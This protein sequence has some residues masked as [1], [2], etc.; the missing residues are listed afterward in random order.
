M[1]FSKSIPTIDNIREPIL[2]LVSESPHVASFIGG[3]IARGWAHA[4]SDVDVVVVVDALPSGDD[5]EQV[6]AGRSAVRVR[7]AVVAGRRCELKYWLA[8][9]LDEAIER[10]SWSSFDR[11]EA[12]FHNEERVLL[13]R[14]GWGVVLTGSPW[15]QSRI[16]LLS[17]GAFATTIAVD[18][19][20]RADAAM[21]DL[22]GAALGGDIMTAT[23]CARRAYGYAVDAFIAS[24]GD[25]GQEGKWRARRVRALGGEILPYD[26]YCRAETLRDHDPEPERWLSQ[27]VNAAQRLALETRLQRGA[28]SK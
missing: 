7:T 4:F 19:L 20:N 13:D 6:R 16:E 9:E 15:L 12:V 11:G 21:E 25:T 2:E 27:M 10:S 24:R 26:D 8:P 1:N 23:L 17:R 18:R 22:A 5:Y 3:S 14:I 28:I